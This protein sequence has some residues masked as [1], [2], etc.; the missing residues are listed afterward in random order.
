MTITIAL[1]PAGWS[2]TFAGNTPMPQGV[3]LPLPFSSAAS[4]ETVR[5][6][7]QSRF[8]NA[9]IHTDRSD[10][11]RQESDRLY[12]AERVARLQAHLAARAGR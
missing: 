7:L 2:A 11:H 5:A 8:P 12:H 10:I 6:N 3:P 4:A 1:T 9:I